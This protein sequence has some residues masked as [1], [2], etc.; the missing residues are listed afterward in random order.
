MEDEPIMRLNLPSGEQFEAVPD[1]TTLFRFAGALAVYNHVYCYDTNGEEVTQ[2]FYIFNF[3]SGYK[4]M[5]EYMVENAYPLHDNLREIS[6]GDIDAYDRA[7]K[8][9]AS[10]IA[11]I[12]KIID[13]W[14]Q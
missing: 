7:V 8:A 2:S 13:S 14:K 10:D 11:D 5:E 6:S 3:I 9:T 12:D 4:T 1:N